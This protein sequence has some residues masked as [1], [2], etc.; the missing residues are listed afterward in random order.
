MKCGF[1]I[2]VFVRHFQF[3][4]IPDIAHRQTLPTLPPK[5]FKQDQASTCSTQRTAWSLKNRSA[6]MGCGNGSINGRSLQNSPFENMLSTFWQGF[7]VV[8]AR[9]SETKILRPNMTRI[10]G[11]TW[12]PPG[13]LLP[14]HFSSLA[15]RFTQAQQQPE[16]NSRNQTDTNMLG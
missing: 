11:K 6:K 15:Q 12:K 2:Q 1:Q 5:P 3:I 9:G 16:S 8:L 4:I 13:S 10:M 7:S 14:A